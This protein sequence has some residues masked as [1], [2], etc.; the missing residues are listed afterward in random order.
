MT[1]L[2]VKRETNGMP[3]AVLIFAAVLAVLTI[4]AAWSARTTGFGRIAP[5][6]ATAVQSL[7]LRFDDQPDGAVVVRRAGDGATIYRIAPETNGFIRATVRGLVQERRRSN[8]GD[9]VPFSLTYWSDGSMSLEDSTTGRRVPLEAFGATNA[10]AFA[11]L[12]QASRGVR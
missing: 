6:A 3:R 4:A 11:Q 1:D 7:S 12:F 2:A 10:G 9:E 8:I 5:P